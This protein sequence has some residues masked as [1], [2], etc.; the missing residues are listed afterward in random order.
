[1]HNLACMP[2]LS[3][4]GAICSAAAPPPYQIFRIGRPVGTVIQSGTLWVGWVFGRRFERR[5]VNRAT[6]RIVFCIFLQCF[7]AISLVISS[8]DLGISL[9]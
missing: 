3:A 1:M 2:D 4:W 8:V 5:R 9:R 6:S 7:D